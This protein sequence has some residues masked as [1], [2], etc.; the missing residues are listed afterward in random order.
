MRAVLNDDN[1]DTCSWISS[2]TTWYRRRRRMAHIQPLSAAQYRHGGYRET[3]LTIHISMNHDSSPLPRFPRLRAK[4]EVG[5]VKEQRR[6]SLK[7]K[8]A[9]LRALEKEEAE[10]VRHPSTCIALRCLRS[11]CGKDNQ[12]VSIPCAHCSGSLEWRRVGVGDEPPA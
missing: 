12:W 2:A 6:A 1:L 11:I 5:R 4:V 9:V 7:N 8:D 3:L 10:L